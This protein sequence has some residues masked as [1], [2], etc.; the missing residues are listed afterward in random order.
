MAKAT[1][2]FL[3]KEGIKM[4]LILQ[5]KEQVTLEAIYIIFSVLVAFDIA[6]GSFKS[7][8]KASFK[9]RSL[10][11]GMFGSMAELMFLL[12]SIIIAKLVP[13]SRFIVYVILVVMILKELSSII[14]NLIECGAK[15][16]AWL[17]RGLKVYNDKLDNI[18]INDLNKDAQ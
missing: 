12:I 2:L 15:V 7:W 8:K 18:D 4:D 17:S 16:P 6:T 13:I 11:D 10:R 5:I 9:S 3:M 14:E 1:F